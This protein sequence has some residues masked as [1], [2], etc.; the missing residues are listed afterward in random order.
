MK[1]VNVTELPKGERTMKHDL[2]EIIDRFVESGS[3]L[4]KIEFTERDYKHA[5]SCYVN[6]HRAV[7]KSNHP[8]KVR[9]INKEVYLVK[10]SYLKRMEA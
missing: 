9:L 10:N 2:L 5:N 8:V 1:L 7:K 3:E 4:V 6:M